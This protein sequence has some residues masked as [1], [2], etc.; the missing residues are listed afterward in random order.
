MVRK[1][2]PAPI[3]RYHS[4]HRL[5]RSGLD[6]HKLKLLN[7]NSAQPGG[8]FSLLPELSQLRS[9]DHFQ[10]FWFA[11]ERALRLPKLCRIARVSGT[12]ANLRS[13]PFS[14][15]EAKAV[16][17]FSERLALP[18]LLWLS[19]QLTE[20][21]PGAGPARA[22]SFK[23]FCKL[24]AD[25]VALAICFFFPV[26]SRGT[27]GISTL[28]CICNLPTSPGAGRTL[29]E[30]ELRVSE[31]FLQT[32]GVSTF[33]CR[34]NQVV[35]LE[36]GRTYGRII[37]ACSPCID[38]QMCAHKKWPNLWTEARLQKLTG[39]S[40]IFF[41]V[42]VSSRAL[43]NLLGLHLSSAS[44]DFKLVDSFLPAPCAALERRLQARYKGTFRKREENLLLL[45]ILAWRV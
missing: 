27:S 34:A 45:W 2:L 16:F 7:P 4:S 26:L 25:G 38:H 41:Q 10:T 30:L 39:L 37:S 21:Y 40:C 18:G 6:F 13:C 29:H 28:L 5:T 33:S 31:A 1:W 22:A 3:V 19:L 15:F 9:S 32:S 12:S 20:S 23:H 11:T 24:E 43:L 44:F 36:D 17:F 35:R 42:K 14:S 8:H